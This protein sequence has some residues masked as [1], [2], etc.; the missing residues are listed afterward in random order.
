MVG[1]NLV[2]TLMERLLMT[3][4][5]VQSLYPTMALWWQPRLLAI[6]QVVLDPAMYGFTNTTKLVL[7]GC[8]SAQTSMERLSGTIWRQFLYP[9][10][11]LS[12]PSVWIKIMD[13]TMFL[14]LVVFGFIN[15]HTP[16]RDGNNLEAILMEMIFLKADLDIQYLYPVTAW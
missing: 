9:V 5:A 11:A 3:G 10:T 4:L 1:L 16:V 7:H 6:M 14:M 12:W 13:Q 8:N 15:T 2:A